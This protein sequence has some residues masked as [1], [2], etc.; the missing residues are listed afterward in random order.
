M[1]LAICGPPLKTLNAASKSRRPDAWRTPR[2]TVVE[3]E[4]AA[5]TRGLQHREARA[6]DELERPNH[7]APRSR[8]QHRERVRAADR[9]CARRLARDAGTKNLIGD[10]H[11]ETEMN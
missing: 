4:G 2:I 11:M 5:G 6:A 8:R 3:S 10:T 1:R 7:P 9:R